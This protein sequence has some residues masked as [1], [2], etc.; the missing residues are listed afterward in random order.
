MSQ[1]FK[2]IYFADF[3]SDSAK[4]RNVTLAFG[5]KDAELFNNIKSLSSMELRE[6]LGH[7]S[8]STLR[9]AAQRSGLNINPFCLR[10][11]RRRF[12]AAKSSQASLPGLAALQTP[13]IEPIQATFKGGQKEPLH[14]WYPY[15]EGYSPKFV[16]QVIQE[17]APEAQTVL[18]PFAGTGTTPLTVARRGR[19]ASYCELNPLLQ[20]LIEAKL[21]ALGLD[22]KS[23]LHVSQKLKE[24]AGKFRKDLQ[25][26]ARDVDLQLAYEQTFPSSKF[27]DTS[28]YNDVLR[29]RTLID[30]LSCAEPL[31]AKLV[32]IALLSIIVDISRVIRRGD[33]RFRT[34]QE[35]LR[36]VPT[37]AS[38]MEVRL[39]AIADDVERVQP[40]NQFPTLVTE[41]ATHLAKLQP[42]SVDAL[43]TSPPYLNGTNY[44][45]NT[46]L[47]L[48]FLRCLRSSSDLSDFRRKA[49]TAGIN[50]VTLGKPEEELTADIADVVQKLSESAYDSRIPRMVQGYFSD[51]KRVFRAVRKHLKKN[52]PVVIDIG[53]SAYGGVH[54]PTDLLLTSILKDEGYHLDREIVLRKRTSRGGFSLRQVLLIFRAPETSSRSTSKQTQ[55]FWR[56]RWTRFKNTLPH[57]QGDFAKRNWGHALHSLCS[58]QGKMKPALAA[59]L[60]RIFLKPN[61]SMLDPFAGVGTI[62]FEAALQGVHASAFEISPAALQIASAKM[63]QPLRSECSDIIDSL[64]E[65]IAG[66][67]LNQMDWTSMESVHFNG[68]IREYF[69]EQT[70]AEVLLARRFFQKHPPQTPS[71]SLVL[72][73]L[74]HILH[75]NRPYALSRRSHPITP[76]AP[77]GDYEYRSLIERLRD[78]VERSLAVE[79]PASF[80][81]GKVYHQD[82]LSWWPQ[83]IQN[84]D[85]IITSPPF[86]D[87]TRFHVTN[88][89]RLWFCG[90]EALD[91]KTQPLAFIDERQKRSLDIYESMFRQSR[92]RLKSTGVL[93][94]HLGKSKKCDM[95]ERLAQIGSRWF[96]VADVFTENVGHCESHGIR[97]QGTVVAHQYLVLHG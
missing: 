75:G 64:K 61:Q 79:Y 24:L 80:V 78:K 82:T 59:H 34:E 36:G 96:R 50:D 58:Y 74:L 32:T 90:W 6:L 83:E 73:S 5:R 53:D 44:F 2:N 16:E 28:T 86:F 55:P 17:F 76:F 10:V 95:A 56:S 89:M 13:V 70:L 8:F 91:F 26:A 51:M 7:S 25:N 46:K 23:R 63:G 68:S 67:K 29:A 18:D 47:E 81:P 62:P 21:L 77:T 9:A 60:I 88:W 30:G 1:E 48:W 22:S 39:N 33:L 3:P 20:Y 27:F 15:V 52:A 72:S 40:I 57:Q 4:K 35:K 37:L 41:D 42:L 31:I 66:E 11:L 97:D 19:A 93:V 38:A 87:S 49:V 12:D 43:I 94:L 65:F 85:A 54:V 45:R 92:E 14:G 69:H 71:A 84:L